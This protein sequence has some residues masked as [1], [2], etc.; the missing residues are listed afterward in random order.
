M[1][2]TKE[3]QDESE[4]KTMDLLMRFG[5]E[6]TIDDA[7][8][9]IKGHKCETPWCSEEVKQWNMRKMERWHRGLVRLRRMISPVR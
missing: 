5:I 6:L 1:V 9:W 4:K 2:Q 8:G 7:W 3:K